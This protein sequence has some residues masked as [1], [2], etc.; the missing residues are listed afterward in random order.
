MSI[1]FL[2]DEN[3][4]YALIYLLEKRGFP[5]QHLKKQELLHDP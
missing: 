3:I 5:V 1:E 4:P 2:L